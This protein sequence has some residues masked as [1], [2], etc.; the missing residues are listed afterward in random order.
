MN[1]A[2]AS[3]EKLLF[4]LNEE[5]NLSKASNQ[6]PPPT[7]SFPYYFQVIFDFLFVVGLSPIWISF[8]DDQQT[9]QFKQYTLQKVK[10]QFQLRP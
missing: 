5:G 2:K 4:F 6:A 7:Y 10:I 8:P 9:V 1:M 3:R